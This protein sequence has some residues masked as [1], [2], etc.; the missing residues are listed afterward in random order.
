MNKY[1][2]YFI[3]MVI[4]GL[5]VSLSL[6]FINELT[7]P[8]I[9]EQKLKKV[10]Q[11]LLKVDSTNKWVSGEKYINI[12]DD[13]GIESIYIS[14]NDKNEYQFI[15]YYIVTK[16]YSNGNIESLI[17]IN[18]NKKTINNVEII[19]IENQTKGIGSLIKDDPNYVNNFK[20]VKIEKYFNDNI[21]NHNNESSDIISGATISSRGVVQAVITASNNY[22]KNVGKQYE[23]N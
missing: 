10:E 21:N 19:N 22:F 11:S 14:L 15:A 23:S 3:F 1:L 9:E 13:E 20:D 8:I 7:A 4:L 2:K 17:F 16:G 5:I 12:S 6:S 18:N